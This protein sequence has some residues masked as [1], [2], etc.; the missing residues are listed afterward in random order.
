MKLSL[1]KNF[2]LF[3][4]PDRFNSSSIEIG[5]APWVKQIIEHFNL[6]SLGVNSGLDMTWPRYGLYKYGC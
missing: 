1:G 6:G 3:P 5:V 2:R 4:I